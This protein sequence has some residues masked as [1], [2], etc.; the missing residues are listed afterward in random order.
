MAYYFYSSLVKV[1]I[2]S[3]Q[4]FLVLLR[5]HAC[6]CTKTG[7]DSCKMVIRLSSEW[8]GTLWRMTDDNASF[9]EEENVVLRPIKRC[10]PFHATKIQHAASPLSANVPQRVLNVCKCADSIVCLCA[11]ENTQYTQ[12]TQ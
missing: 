12:Y 6:Y 3:I 2:V 4:K 8:R 1:G 10:F 7:G 11:L 5:L 9:C